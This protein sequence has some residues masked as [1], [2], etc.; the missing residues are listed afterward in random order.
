MR[1]KFLL[2]LLFVMPLF[3]ACKIGQQKKTQ[4]YTYPEDWAVLA[5]KGIELEL[6]NV[7][8][9]CPKLGNNLIDHY[10]FFV[11]RTNCKFVYHI[12]DSLILQNNLK[13]SS[14]SIYVINSY[15]QGFN[16]YNCTRF[17][18]K[19][20]NNSTITNFEGCRNDPYPEVT[21]KSSFI[22]NEE[23]P[24]DKIDFDYYMNLKS[25]CNMDGFFVVTK[26]NTEFKILDIRVA[27][28]PTP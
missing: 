9:I 24:E 11:D 19:G 17:I 2:L 16:F 7:K 13:D 26:L 4:I 21:F 20:R 8:K 23:K 28:M 1:N 10:K 5:G 14:A 6:P 25:N 15:I 12:V 3:V 27:L 18:V 22:V